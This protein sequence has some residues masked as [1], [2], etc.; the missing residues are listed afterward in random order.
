[1]KRIEETKS[2]H[3]WFNGLKDKTAKRRID[4]GIARLL[5][6]NTGN[7]KQIGEKVFELTIDYGP[8]YR[9]YYMEIGDSLV[10]LLL[11]GDKSS[12]RRDIVT[13]KV[14]AWKEMHNGNN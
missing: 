3:K 11:G 1:M 9:V 6:G 5:L 8:G 14:M 13:A 10:L 12:Q 2:Y 4:I 7:V